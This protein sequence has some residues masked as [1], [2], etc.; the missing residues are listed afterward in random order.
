VQIRVYGAFDQ[1]HYNAFPW[2][3]SEYDRVYG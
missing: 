2:D 1:Q 3:I